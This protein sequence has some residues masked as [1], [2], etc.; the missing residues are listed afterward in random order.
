MI[1][2][3]LYEFAIGHNQLNASGN[4]PLIWTI[5]NKHCESVKEVL[6]FDYLLCSK[7]YTTMEREKKELHEHMRK[8]FLQI[9]LLMRGYQLSAHGVGG[10]TLNGD[11]EMWGKQ[12]R[13]YKEVNKIDLLKKNEFDKSILSE[14]LN[15]QD[16]DILHLVLS[17]PMSS[18][19]NEKDE[20]AMSAMCIGVANRGDSAL[21]RHNGT[22]FT[23]NLEDAKI[24][25]K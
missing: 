17:H 21:N 6:L 2:F 9:S 15:A 12:I 1:R 19:L 4:S 10:A 3:L 20:S 13:L 11:G 22:S 14:S 24:I 25:Q 7:E 5:Q 16:E 23:T 18:V 8:D